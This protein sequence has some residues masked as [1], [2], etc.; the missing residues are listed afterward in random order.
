MHLLDAVENTLNIEEMMTA[1][2]FIV[3]E[4]V[5]GDLFLQHRSPIPQP[6]TGMAVQL[7][8]ALIGESSSDIP[9]QPV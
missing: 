1:Q 5:K 3:L 6:P 9:G 2:N 8:V 7:R 4:S